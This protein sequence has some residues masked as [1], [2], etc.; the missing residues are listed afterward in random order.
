MTRSNSLLILDRQ[1]FGDFKTIVKAAK[2]IPLKNT[3]R[4]II[5][6]SFNSNTIDY[7]FRMIRSTST[8]HCGFDRSNS[9]Y[10]S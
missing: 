9:I 8:E 4:A 10:R 6:A 7:R 1:L 2:N 5:S 3:I